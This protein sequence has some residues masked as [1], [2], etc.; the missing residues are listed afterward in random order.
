VQQGQKDRKDTPV[1]L[2][3]KEIAV[4][5]A[6]RVHAAIQ[7]LRVSRAFKACK[8]FVGCRVIPVTLVLLERPDSWVQLARQE[9]RDSLELTVLPALRVCR[10]HKVTSARKV[11]LARVVIQERPDCRDPRGPSA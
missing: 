2:A 9:S 8:A 6:N 4:K 10:A 5:Q 11:W 3:R 7:V 1:T